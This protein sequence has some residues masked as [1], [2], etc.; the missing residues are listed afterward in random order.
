ML[1]SFF[2]SK[3]PMV[4]LIGYHSIVFVLIY[5]TTNTS[6]F[7]ILRSSMYQQV[8]FLIIV[9]KKLIS[10][11]ETFFQKH[12]FIF[13]MGFGMSFHFQNVIVSCL[14]LSENRNGLPVQL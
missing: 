8:T 2:F 11:I 14:T 4:K 12:V 5:L 9:S 3:S 6:C 13:K 1:S 10:G 7:M